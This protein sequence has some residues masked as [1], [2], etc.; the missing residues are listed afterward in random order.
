MQKW[1]YLKI[2]IHADW[3][4]DKIIICSIN[5][6]DMPYKDKTTHELLNEFGRDG[7]ELA[8]YAN[9]SNNHIMIMKRLQK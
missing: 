2:Y 1:E 6:K 4:D 9:S 3:N 8:G 7:W 5:G